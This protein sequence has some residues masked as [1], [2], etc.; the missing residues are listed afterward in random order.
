MKEQTSRD[1]VHTIKKNHKL[2]REDM[3]KFLTN[4]KHM[5]LRIGR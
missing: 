1:G 5:S 2:L 3:T 4:I